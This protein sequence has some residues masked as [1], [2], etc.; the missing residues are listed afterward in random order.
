MD[1]NFPESM[2]VRIVSEPGRFFVASAVSVCVNIIAATKVNASRIF[3]KRKGLKVSYFAFIFD[4][5]LKIFLKHPRR[6]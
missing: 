1:E 4:C 5:F 3:E 6:E 2:G